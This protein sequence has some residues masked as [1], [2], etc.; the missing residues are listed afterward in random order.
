MSGTA[1]LSDRAEKVAENS[2]LKLISRIVMGIGVPIA[3]AIAGWYL[4]T[5]ND[6]ISFLKSAQA[7]TVK[8][9]QFNEAIVELTKLNNAIDKRTTTLET[10]TTLGRNDRIEFQKEQSAAVGKILEQISLVLQNQAANTTQLAGIVQRLD[11]SDKRIDN[12]DVR[13]NSLGKG[14]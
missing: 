11:A 3:I 13:L 10:T 9:E 12:L 5:V 6:S 4:T 14:P 8:V 2:L 7:S 1:T